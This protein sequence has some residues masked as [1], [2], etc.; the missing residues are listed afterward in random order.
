MCVCVRRAWWIL[1]WFTYNTNYTPTYFN[2]VAAFIRLYDELG[3]YRGETARRPWSDTVPWPNALLA[4]SV[5]HS[6]VWGLFH[7]RSCHLN[8]APVW[9]W[10]PLWE[11]RSDPGMGSIE[12]VSPPTRRRRSGLFDS[13]VFIIHTFWR[14]FL[15]LQDL[16]LNGRGCA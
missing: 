5:V 8:K 13:E 14:L 12:T 3:N 11:I 15:N 10:L 16:I 6:F 9:R 4:S 1:R 2:L 7:S